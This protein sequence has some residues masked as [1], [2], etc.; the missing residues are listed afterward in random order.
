MRK[1]ARLPFLETA[2][3]VIALSGGNLF[4]DSGLCQLYADVLLYFNVT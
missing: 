3:G 1:S 4:S 2:H